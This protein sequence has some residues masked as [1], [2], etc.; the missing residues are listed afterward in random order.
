MNPAPTLPISSKLARYAKAQFGCWVGPS[1]SIMNR[2][3]FVNYRKASIKK[4]TDLELWAQANFKWSSGRP[5][6]RVFNFH[7]ACTR[8]RLV[9]SLKLLSRK[10]LIWSSGGP[11]LGFVNFLEA[12]MLRTHTHTH[13]HTIRSSGGP[14]RI[15][16]V[17]NSRK[18]SIQTI[19][20]LELWKAQVMLKPC[21]HESLAGPG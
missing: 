5:R 18:A 16:Y 1:A 20:C 2:L 10:S 7:N 15:D 11:R 19:I 4:V 13:I 9:K 17:V 12:C 21:L 14:H 3:G 6:Q 8:L